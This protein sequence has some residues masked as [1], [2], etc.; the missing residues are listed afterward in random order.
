MC[1]QRESLIFVRS[2]TAL[3]EKHMLPYGYGIGPV[4][5]RDNIGNFIIVDAHGLRAG[6]YEVLQSL[7]HMRRKRLTPELKIPPDQRLI[8]H[9]ARER[10]IIVDAHGLRTRFYEVLQSLLH[11]RREWHKAGGLCTLEA[12]LGRHRQ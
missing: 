12:C 8:R 6:S 1:Q 9:G 5:A 2:K 4:R 11:M 7:L 3:T 10:Y